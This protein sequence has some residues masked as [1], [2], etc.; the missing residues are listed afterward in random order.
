MVHQYAAGNPEM[1][2]EKGI[3]GQRGGHGLEMTVFDRVLYG[4]YRSYG[5]YETHRSHTS[6]A[7]HSRWGVAAFHFAA[8]YVLEYASTGSRPMEK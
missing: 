3:F 4:T 2:L 7:S 5:I 8:Y 6:S 1:K